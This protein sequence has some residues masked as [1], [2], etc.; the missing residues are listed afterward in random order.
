ME[1][2]KKLDPSSIHFDQQNVNSL[3]L[4]HQLLPCPCKIGDPVYHFSSEK[5][6][7]KKQTERSMVRGLSWVV[8]LP[9]HQQK[10]SKNLTFHFLVSSMN[11]KTIL[12][13]IIII[14][15][16]I[17]FIEDTFSRTCGFPKEP[18]G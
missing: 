10:K 11:D 7:T 13:L 1:F 14:I 17:I 3:L 12:R 9:C 8:A 16:I 18:K 6:K 15:I 5:K 4:G 2:W